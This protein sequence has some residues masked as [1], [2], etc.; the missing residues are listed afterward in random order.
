MVRGRP[1]RAPRPAA[2]RRRSGRAERMRTRR[3]R[4]ASAASAPP[5][6][7]EALAKHDCPILVPPLGRDPARSP[8][9]YW[10]GPRVIPIFDLKYQR[11]RSSVL[12]PSRG[13]GKVKMSTLSGLTIP[14]QHPAQRV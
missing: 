6:Y 1:E 14:I 5:F 3:T 4:L 10:R 9:C 12:E 2:A 13:K 11:F 7:V 8:A